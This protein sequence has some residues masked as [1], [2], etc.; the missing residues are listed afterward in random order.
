MKNPTSESVTA[1][2]L[3]A[4]LSKAGDFEGVRFGAM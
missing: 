1:D 4:R 2:A 3:A